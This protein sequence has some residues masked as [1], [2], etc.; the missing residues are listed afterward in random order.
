MIGQ[1]IALGPRW[2]GSVTGGT[3]SC[4]GSGCWELLRYEQR[5]ERH[6]LQVGLERAELFHLGLAVGRGL[7]TGSLAAS[8]ASFNGS[9]RAFASGATWSATFSPPLS[10]A[11]GRPCRTP[12]AMND[13]THVHF[14]SGLGVIAGLDPAIHHSSQEDGC[15]GH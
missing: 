7:T 4:R 3:G 15:A 14:L 6:H 13:D 1:L 11:S 5:H 10:S 9:A 2:A 8:A 12:L